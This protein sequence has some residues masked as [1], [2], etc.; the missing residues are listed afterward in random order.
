MSSDSELGSHQFKL[1]R[2]TV[3]ASGTWADNVHPNVLRLHIHRTPFDE[4]MHCIFSKLPPVFL[5]LLFHVFPLW[6]LPRTFIVKKQKPNWDE[7][8]ENEKRMYERL[9]PLQ[10]STIPICFGEVVFEDRRALILSDV[11]NLSLC[12]KPAWRRDQQ[13]ISDMLDDAFRAL[14]RFGVEY[15]DLK[16]DNFHITSTPSGEKIVIV[17]L[18]SVEQLDPSCTPERAIV[19]SCDQLLRFWAN[20]VEAEREEMGE[21]NRP[22][23][24][25]PRAPVWPR[26]DFPRPPRPPRL[27]ELSSKDRRRLEEQKNV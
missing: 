4:Y 7:E 22:P 17:D 24:I 19:Y 1:G 26:G 6:T 13:Q 3:T 11:G 20:A 27:P 5:R 18:E 10:G 15:G 9:R 8:F 2:Q 25:R 23:V 16:L 12:D 21:L 14:T